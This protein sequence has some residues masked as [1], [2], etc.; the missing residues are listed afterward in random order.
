[1]YIKILS[2]TWLYRGYFCICP[3]KKSFELNIKECIKYRIFSNLNVILQSKYCYNMYTF[4]IKNRG[5]KI[6]SWRVCGFSSLIHKP[7]VDSSANVW[8]MR[9]QLKRLNVFVNTYNLSK[10]IF[11]FLYK[12]IKIYLFTNNTNNV[13]YTSIM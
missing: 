8:Q 6:T 9:S 10:F 11:G 4:G 5:M 13:P 2:F 7:S 12:C 3:Y 1:M